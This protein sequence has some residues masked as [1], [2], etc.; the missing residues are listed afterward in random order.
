MLKQAIDKFFVPKTWEHDRSQT[1]GSSESG[2]CLRKTWYTK[3]KH[4]PDDDHSQ[5]YGATER[6][7]LI[8]ANLFVPA[9]RKAFGDRLLFA[10]DDQKT[11]IGKHLSA[12]PDGIITGL[13]RNALKHLGVKD[14]GSDCIAIE[15]KTIDP[16]VDVTEAKHQNL[17]QVHVAMGMIRQHTK[18]QPEYALLT[19]IDASF[20]DTVT[21]F[22]IHFDPEIFR[23]A[24][25]RAVRV[26][27]AKT[28]AELKPEGY[29]KGG[30]ACDYC[31]F[32]RSCG[33][34]RHNLPSAK[35][36]ATDVPAQLRAEFVDMTREA[37][38]IKQQRDAADERY[39][40]AQEG[41]KERLREKGIVKIEGVLTWSSV[42]GRKQYDVEALIAAAKKKGVDTDKFLKYGEATSRL[43]LTPQEAV[44]Q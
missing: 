2:D 42:K 40:E 16:R 43:T 18:Y 3:N 27:T 9:L 25:A 10:G 36:A 4:A 41:I 8:E 20:H 35:W 15:C 12:T 33:I 23:Q 37:L 1:V 21:E 11:L 13:K 26:L 44:V 28:A 24:E 7:N 39:K 6:G 32:V 30:K 17:I 14:I 31:P 22:A 5:R 19:Y 38:L 34:E 29:I